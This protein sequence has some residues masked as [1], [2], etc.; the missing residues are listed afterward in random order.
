MGSTTKSLKGQ[1]H[2]LADSSFQLNVLQGPSRQGERF[3]AFDAK[4]REHDLYPLQ[5]TG[6]TILQIN[7]GKMCNQTCKH[8][9]VDAGP[10]RK[11]IMT[12]ETME[13]CLE[14]LRQAPDIK[15]VDLTG[16][17]P[18]MNPDFRWFVEELSQLGRQVMVRC[19]LTIILANKKYHDLPLFFKKHRV[20]VV[21][22]LPYFQASRTDA[23]RGDGVFEKSIQA[24]QLLNEVGYGKE[25]TGL[26]LD[27][28]YN[29]SGAFLPSGQASLEAEFKRRLKKGYDID[30]NSLFCITNLPVSRYLDYL[31][32]SG[33]Y[34]S[35]MQKL[36]DAFNPV[37]AMGVMCRN[38]VSVGWDGYLYDCDFN[39]MLDLKVAQSAPQHIR[40]FDLASL[41]KRSIVLNQH[42]YGCTAGAG[43]SCGGETV[44]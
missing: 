4:L 9:H 3:P 14:A 13:L 35:Y 2:A 12:R 34:D 39:Q 36:V 7:V 16:G 24:L 29:P 8:C 18:E 43:S 22:S 1:Q 38:T 17:A 28:V 10:D 32:K 25:G 31:V 42:C 19:N 20:H 37:A 23:Q 26:Q 6:T 33:N 27:L 41:D 11:E 5:P 40:D 15:T 30:F 21:S 44:K